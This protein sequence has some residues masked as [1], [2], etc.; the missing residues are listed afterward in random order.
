MRNSGEKGARGRGNLAGE[1]GPQGMPGMRGEVPRVFRRWTYEEEAG[2]GSEPPGN[3][4]DGVV[5]RSVTERGETSVG[6]ADLGKGGKEEEEEEDIRQK[7]IT[8]KRFH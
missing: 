2:R 6:K 3:P 7:F 1:L 4:E 5:G 8:S